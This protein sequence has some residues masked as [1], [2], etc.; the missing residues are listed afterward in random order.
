MYQFTLNFYTSV[1]A[2]RLW[3][4]VRKTKILADWR[5]WWKKVRIGRFG[6]PY[7]SP[8]PLNK[9]WNDWK[10]TTTLLYYQPTKHVSLLVLT[11]TDYF[12]KMDA[13]AND[14][15]T[16]QEL[17]RYPCVQKLIIRILCTSF[18][19]KERVIR[20]HSSGVLH[21]HKKYRCEKIAERRMPQNC[22]N[23]M[24][25][26]A[27]YSHAKNGCPKGRRRNSAFGPWGDH[28]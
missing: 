8:D 22:K 13:L 14:K 4:R 2:I 1:F 18:A 20:F 11:K 21:R 7:S 24:K 25:K 6:Y 3:F 26:K 19:Y 16:Y 10:T 17:K 9:H 27:I 15:Q 12:D 23:D 5:N 28:E